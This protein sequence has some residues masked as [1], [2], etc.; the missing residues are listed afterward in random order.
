MKDWTRNS[1]SSSVTA[2]ATAIAILRKTTR[3]SPTYPRELCRSVAFPGEPCANNGGNSEGSFLFN[4]MLRR[5]RVTFLKML[6]H[7]LHHQFEGQ[8][9]KLFI[10]H[11]LIRNGLVPFHP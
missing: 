8:R 1:R 7:L 9:P 6:V 10:R 3:D 4:T 11:E 2:A 5:W